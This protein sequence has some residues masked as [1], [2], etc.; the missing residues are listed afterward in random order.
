[1]TYIFSHTFIDKF[2]FLNPILNWGKE[3]DSWNQFWTNL[4][5]LS[6][7]VHGA[8]FYILVLG[9]LK[10]KFNIKEINPFV[11]LSVVLN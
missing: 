8:F 7:L 10:N 2:Q 4:Y 5:I 3:L 6:K 1:M 9:T 11:Q